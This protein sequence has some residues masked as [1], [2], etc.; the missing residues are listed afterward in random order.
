MCCSGKVFEGGKGVKL[1]EVGT[2]V[3]LGK[4]ADWVADDEGNCE[5]NCFEEGGSGVGGFVDGSGFVVVV[6]GGVAMR[7]AP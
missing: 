5:A 7:V 6:V 4:W 1:R 2:E 3:V